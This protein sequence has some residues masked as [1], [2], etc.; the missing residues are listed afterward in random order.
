MLGSNEYLPNNHLDPLF[1]H[2][3]MVHKG[4]EER[5]IKS[6]EH[7]GVETRDQNYKTF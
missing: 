2:H 5:I 4:A 6:L 7:H 3:H 1:R